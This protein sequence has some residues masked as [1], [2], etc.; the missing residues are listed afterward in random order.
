MQLEIIISRDTD[1]LVPILHDAEEDDVR[2]TTAIADVANTG[3]A[4][5]VDGE[6]VGAALMHWQTDVSELIYIAIS[7]AY[8]GKGYGKALIA[9]LL[10]IARQQPTEA[11][12]V[13]TAN[14]S[15]ENISFYQTCGFRMDSVRKDYFSYFQ[16]PVYEHGILMQDM[17]MLRHDLA[18]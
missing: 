5:F 9:E 7:S 14:T 8:R 10:N 16:T 3:Y 17:L 4:A 18:T 13:G 2:I 15:I 6:C 12:I 11:L 1:L